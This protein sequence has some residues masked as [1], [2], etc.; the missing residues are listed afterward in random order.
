V[1]TLGGIS[2]LYLEVCS[3]LGEAHVRLKTDGAFSSEFVPLEMIERE[4]AYCSGV[5][6]ENAGDILRA[7]TRPFV[8]EYMSSG[9]IRF[10]L[11]PLG[12]LEI[13]NAS[14][15]HERPKH[16]EA[17]LMRVLSFRLDYTDPAASDYGRFFLASPLPQ[18][19]GQAAMEDVPFG[20]IFN[21]AVYRV[22]PLAQRRRQHLDLVIDD[23]GVIKRNRVSLEALL[24]KILVNVLLSTPKDRTVRVSVQKAGD[25]I[26]L[27]IGSWGLDGEKLRATWEPSSGIAGAYF[28][29]GIPIDDSML[30]QLNIKLALAATVGGGCSM[31]VELPIYG[32]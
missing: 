4:V 18:K 1:E 27:Y 31:Q 14:V 26:Q 30:K 11:R 7:L 17:K 5:S 16:E 6:P 8:D 20:T 23:V 25:A 24:R 13:L 3:M 21:L 15:L 22:L 2:N 32:V 9:A 28:D 19:V 10:R 29:T 12:V